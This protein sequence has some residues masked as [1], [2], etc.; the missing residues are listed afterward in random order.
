MFVIVLDKATLVGPFLSFDL[1]ETYGKSLGSKFK[2]MPVKAS[3]DSM[4]EFLE[5][6]RQGLV[7]GSNIL[8]SLTKPEETKPND[9]EFRRASDLLMGLA[10]RLD[11]G[12]EVLG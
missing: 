4:Q 2:I 6:V 5:E 8:G 7:L 11:Y 3:C 10:N 1:A 12:E 9:S